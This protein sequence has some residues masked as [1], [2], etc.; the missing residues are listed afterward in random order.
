MHTFTSVALAALTLALPATAQTNAPFALDSHIPKTLSADQ[1]AQAQTAQT[2]GVFS[3][4]KTTLTFVAP[5]IHLVAITGPEDDMLSYRIQGARNPTIVVPANAMLDITFV[6]TDDDMPHDFHLSAAQP[7]FAIAPDMTGA[8]GSAKLPHQNDEQYS[9]EQMTIRAT[10]A[11]AYRYFCSVRGHA[12]GGM[13]GTILVGEAATPDAKTAPMQDR[14]AMPAMKMPGAHAM[15][16]MRSSVDLDDP[17]SRESSGTSWVPD[18]SPIYAA[19]KMK[20]DRMLMLHGD[21]F[22]RY[23]TIGG[24]RDVAASGQGGNSRFDAP[25]MFMAMA[26]QPAG[27]NAQIGVRLMTSLDPIIERGYGYPLL[28]QSGES[29]KSQPLHDRQHP[30]DLISELS[31]TYSRKL[32][33]SNSAYLYLGLPGEPALGPPVFMHRISGMDNPDAPISHHWQDSTHIAFG[34]VTAGVSTGKLKFEAS[35]F[36]GQE[37]DENRYSFDTPRLD[38]F[39]GRVSW[40]P[41]RDL[42]LQVSHGF[43]KHPEALEPDVSVHRTTASVIYNKPLGRDA[44]W[45]NTFVWGQNNT[46]GEGRSNSYLFETNYQKRADTVYARFERVQK[47]GHELVLA[48]PNLDKLFGVGSYA[49][50]YV[51]NVKH[52]N[53]LDVGVGAQV[54]FGTNP[55]ELRELYGGRNHTGFQVFLRL[56]PSRMDQNDAMA[57]MKMDGMT[58]GKNMSH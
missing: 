15:M 28:Y 55:A 31:A 13:F 6:N 25:S 34:V 37:P 26:S 3:A 11:G 56:R 12:K 39:S 17:M 58:M 54:T 42:A 47:S 24:K 30:H 21:I 23:T 7:P 38:S 8:V 19:M 27:K 22:P 35:T 50:G 40:N 33:K 51:H 2:P 48:P 43:V 20:G 41:T 46:G 5:T 49:F 1:L 52:N 45:A 9:A 16:A 29:Y 4:D 53:G 36:K 57:N 10:S 18:S 44:N 14:G 32:S